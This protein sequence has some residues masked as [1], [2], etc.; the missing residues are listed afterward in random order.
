ML[1]PGSNRRVFGIDAN[2]GMVI[3]GFVADGRQIVNRARDEARSYRETYGHQ[4]VPDI[5][6]NRL[7]LYVHYFTTHG[8]LRPFGATSIVASYDQ[9]L[10][11][12]TL[13]MVEPSGNCFKYFGCAAGKGSQAAKTEIEKLLYN[14]K[15][16]FAFSIICFF[17]SK[18]KA[19]NL[20]LLNH[21][22]KYFLKLEKYLNKNQGFNLNHTKQM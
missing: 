8:A 10:K 4:I 11:S 14:K 20:K 7:A 22:R 1:V 6:A 19:V 13:F 12:H 5:L 9:D 18:K 3:T 17:S 15:R 2:S 21:K 16:E